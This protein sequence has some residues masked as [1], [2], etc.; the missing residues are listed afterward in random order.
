[1]RPAQSAALHQR[2]T[3]APLALAAAM[4]FALAAGHAPLARAQG[5][6]ATTAA[7][8]IAIN[9]AA[10]PLGQALNE[11]ARLA[12]LQMTFPAA[13]VAGKQAPAVSGNLTVRQALERLLAGSGLLAAQQGS[14]VVV[15]RAPAP[16][17]ASEA[18]LPAVQVVAGSEVSPGELPKPFAGGQVATGARLGMLGNVDVLTTPFSIKAYTEQVIKDQGARSIDDLVANDPSIRVSLSPGFVLDQSSIR[19]FLVSSVNYR[20]D[21]MPGLFW[22]SRVPAA[23][24]ERIEVLKGP[25]TGVYG[26]GAFNSSVGG[27]VNLVPKRATATPVSSITVGVADQS[28][29]STHVDLGRRFGADN[30]FGIRL[31]VFGEKGELANTTQRGNIAPQLAL[32]F[33]GERVR[34]N[35]DAGYNHYNNK[36]PGVNHSLQ[37]GEPVPAVPNPRRSAQP[38]WANMALDSWFGLVGAEFDITPNLTAFAKHGRY[39]EKN[40]ESI[41]ASP[42]PVRGDGSFTVN[43]VVYNTWT[44]DNKSTDL[45]LRAK[46]TTGNV[47]HQLT[48]SSLQYENLYAI[49]T[50]GQSTSPVPA[51]VPVPGTIYADYPITNPFP[52]GFPSVGDYRGTPVKQRSFGFADSMTLLNDRLNVVV[53]LRSQEI[54]EGAYKSKKNAPTLAA[55]YQLG[56]GFTV[57]GNY[58]ETLIQGAQAPTGT[59]NAGQNLSPYVA[60][61]REL[62]LKWNA[63]TY[64][65]TTAFFDIRQASA[66]TDP[67]D[68]VFKAAGEQCNRGIEIESFGEVTKG[69]R[70]L[71][72]VAYIDAVQTKTRAGAT[73]G[74]KAL[75][76]PAFTM[77]LG[78][79]VDV[80]SMPGLTLSARVI[81][82]GSAYVDLVNTQKLPSWNRVDVAARYAT[83]LSGYPV[84]W[85]AGVNNL[86]DKAYWQSG[87][88]NIVTVAEPR[89]WRL[90][91]SMDF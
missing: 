15:T 68:N 91:A 89:T 88:R 36:R 76:V 8:P 11:L 10:Q 47:K 66:F 53:A 2:F 39:H 51:F 27:T 17:T 14:Q 56:G 30:A 87:G 50:S 63:G 9:I 41:L 21:G 54:Q 64:G 80:S 22:Y 25:S 83:K 43:N 86:F 72:G 3:P 78:G 18:T 20:F 67:I 70:V 48:V 37:A 13:L 35:F 26:A 32:D 12:N 29:V 65:V 44:N 40:D 16:G 46:L 7:T 62:G 49:P 61:Q 90:S 24:F 58:A 71:G 69:V 75:G 55:S 81:H 85:R 42:G 1:M 82:T 28:L 77:N 6:A 52:G 45:G 79:E 33:T 19:G 84:T 31:N 59:A 4:A 23:N 38:E 34:L 73:D 74:K 57:Y 5:G 60:E